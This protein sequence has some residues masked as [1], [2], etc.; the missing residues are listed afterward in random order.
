MV[1]K[2]TENTPDKST[3]KYVNIMENMEFRGLQIPLFEVLGFVSFKKH[4]YRTQKS[5]CTLNI[6]K[7]WMQRAQSLNKAAKVT[8]Q[9]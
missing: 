8:L 4:T 2:Y 1:T 3:L 7:P 9:N 6:C 5:N